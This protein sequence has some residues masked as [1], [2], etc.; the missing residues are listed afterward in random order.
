MTKTRYVDDVKVQAPIDQALINHVALVVDGSGSM[1]GLE[2]TV[3]RVVDELMA[4]L[5]SKSRETDQE[6][7]VS[8]Y[9]FENTLSIKC[10][11]YDKDVLRMPSMKG[12]YRAV[13]NT[14]LID[15]TLK[16]IDDLKQSATLYG[17]HAFLIYVLTDG[18]ENASKHAPD[19]LRKT[20]QQ[21]DENWTLACFVPDRTSKNAAERFGFPADNVQLWEVTEGGLKD[22]ARTITNSVSSYYT[23]RSSGVRGSKNLFSMDLSK[24]SKSTIA[25]KLTPLTFG[26]YRM[27]DVKDKTPIAHFV[28]VQLRRPYKLGEAYYQLT[29]PVKVQ[30]QKQVCIWDRKKHVLYAGNEARQL[31][32]L[33]SYEVKLEPAATPDFDIFIQSTSVNRNL[34][35]GQK[36]V[37]LS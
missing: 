3:V 22:A 7:R 34:L 11:T 29:E 37:V 26:Q 8:L 27:F 18:A 6:T 24:L 16:S 30:P 23:M 32:G 25:K 2:T 1:A 33:P 21:L 5:A 15:A 31:L 13:G 4:T 14:P 9:V 10:L 17:D 12:L 20:I 19:S 36:V 28:E 35:P